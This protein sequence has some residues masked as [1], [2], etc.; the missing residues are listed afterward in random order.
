MP[1]TLR[2]TL[3]TPAELRVLP[4]VYWHRVTSTAGERFF[5]DEWKVASEADRLGYRFRGGTALEFVPH[6]QP[7]GAGADPSNI[8]GASRSPAG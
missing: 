3:G 1:E 8:T 5:A 4:G 6:E 2:H 7:F